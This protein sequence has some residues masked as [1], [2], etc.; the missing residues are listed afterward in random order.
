LSGVTAVV[1][2]PPYQ[3][4]FMGR[5]W[6]RSGVSFEP[7]TWRGVLATCLPGAP[8]L[9]FGGCRTY[10]RL[11]CAIEDAG[12][13]VCNQLA[14]IF[15]QGFPKALDLSKAIDKA[16]GVW[17]GRAGEVV[18]R[19]VGQV[20]KGTEY[21][22]TPKGAPATESAKL[23]DGW[24]AGLQNLKPGMEPIC[25]AQ[26]PIN[27]TYAAN[28]LEH[29]V[30][31]L[32][33]EGGRVPTEDGYAENCVTQGINQARTSYAPAGVRKTFEPGT[34]R[35]PANVILS[36]PEDEYELRD[37]VT[38]DELRHLAEWMDANA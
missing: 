16:A 36:Y 24:C 18:D 26:K 27:G 15:A 31:G 20:A 4:D 10:H 23:W 1:T 3:I 35:W 33:I 19:T 28:A 14:W 8:L 6:D 37:E 34:G 32:N 11:V 21:E 12:W 17:R 5:Q 25:Y 30:A 13:Q 2:D 9:S 38:P 29:G 7:E 22:R